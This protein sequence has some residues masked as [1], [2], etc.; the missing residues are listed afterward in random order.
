[1]RKPDQTVPAVEYSPRSSET[2]TLY[3]V[4]QHHLESWLRNAR[5]HDR[6]VPRFVEHELRAF[7]DCGILANGFLLDCATASLTI[8]S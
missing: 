8:E 5:M 1:V 3:G 7:L 6:T 4:V 2:T